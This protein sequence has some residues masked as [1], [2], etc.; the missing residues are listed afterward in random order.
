MTRWLD[1][2]AISLSGLCLLHCLAGS[3]VL[4]LAATTGGLLS[5]DVHAVGFAVAAPLAGFA[6]WRG[7]LLHQRGAVLVLGVAGLALM[8]GS[9]T[10]AHGTAGEI[11]VS[12]IGVA[13]LALAHLLNLR[14]S[15]G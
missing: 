14:W 12:M 4:S 5:H 9:L 13:L 1:R 11:A 3:L 2:S 15:R 6:L 8:L 10:I 7:V